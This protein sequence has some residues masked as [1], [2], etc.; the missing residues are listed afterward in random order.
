MAVPANSHSVALQQIVDQVL[1]ARRLTRVDQARIMQL[2][3][4]KK[5]LSCDEQRQVD[6]VFDALKRGLVR[7]SD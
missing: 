3:L 7:V 6:R 2:V 4:A 5:C 1:I